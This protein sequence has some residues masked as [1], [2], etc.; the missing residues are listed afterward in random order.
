MSEK[1]YILLTPGPTPLPP[2]VYRKLAE[3][4]LHHRTHEFGE[5]FVETIELL[6]YVYR[7]KNEVLMVT[8]SGS[9]AMESSI[10]NLLSPGDKALIHTT[11]AFGE[12]FVKI[13]PRSTS[14]WRIVW[15][16]RQVVVWFLLKLGRRWP[17]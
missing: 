14:N 16:V 17:A 9:G 11:G 15:T 1:P 10:A 2:S 13:A 4:I 8:S 3:P 6:K 5:K 7:T 12:R